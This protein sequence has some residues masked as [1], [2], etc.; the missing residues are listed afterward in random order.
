M[1]GARTVVEVVT[2]RQPG[3]LLAHALRVS[4]RPVHAR[5][6]RRREATRTAVY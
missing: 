3:A 1:R 6:R 2:A 5:Q 4:G